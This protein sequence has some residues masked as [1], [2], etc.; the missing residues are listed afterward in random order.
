MRHDDLRPALRDRRGV[1]REQRLLPDQ[2]DRQQVGGRRIPS[3]GQLGL[4]S[5]VARILGPAAERHQQPVETG[6]ERGVGEAKPV[7]RAR[8]QP[9]RIH[10]DLRDVQREAREARDL[11]RE[12]VRGHGA[13]RGIG[14]VCIARRGP[15]RLAFVE[16]AGCP[17]ADALC[18]QPRPVDARHVGREIGD[19]GQRDRRRQV[20]R[21]R[22]LQCREI[23]RPQ[24]RRRVGPGREKVGVGD[25]TGLDLRAIGRA[26]QGD[27]G[28][29]HARE[30]RTGGGEILAALA[31]EGIDRDARGQRP[32]RRDRQRRAIGCRRDARERVVVA[33][34]GRGDGIV[35]G[36]RGG[37]ERHG[38]GSGAI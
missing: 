29:G 38:R 24:M 28:T 30:P 34:G 20:A 3:A 25:R 36:E 27:G 6:V 35:G 31:E 32:G 13:P 5:L 22:L 21:G 15:Q 16:M 37:G 23:G 14:A 2:P 17:G 4:P 7:A 19:R 9:E 33:V 10:G 1:A 12:I 8:D 26:R 11:R 18:D